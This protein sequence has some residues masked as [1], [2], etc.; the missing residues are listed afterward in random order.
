MTRPVIP[1]G[2]M[3]ASSTF[4]AFYRA[5]VPRLRR[6]LWRQFPRQRHAVDDAIQH[7]CFQAY[8]SSSDIR[9]LRR[10]VHRAA[11]NFLIDET[12][13]EQ[14]MD[15]SASQRLDQIA[16]APHGDD[17]ERELVALRRAECTEHALQSVG[18]PSRSLVVFK[19]RD[20]RSYVEIAGM[21]GISVRSVGTLLLRARRRVRDLADECMGASSDPAW[22][23]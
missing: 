6:V 4:A 2:A 23:A 1:D 9:D 21:L 11:V 19:H 20:G 22:R 3:R 10:F 14:R 17:E 15:D 8:R 5:E 12:R 18:E 13:G 7:A 16:T